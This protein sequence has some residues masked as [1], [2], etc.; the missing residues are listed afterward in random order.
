MPDDRMAGRSPPGFG[1]Q[2]PAALVSAFVSDVADL[3]QKEI[4]LA[5][6][7]IQ[8]NVSRK[9]RGSV[10]LAVAGLVF[11]AAGLTLVAG[12]ALFITTYGFALYEAAFIVAAALVVLGVIVMVVGQAR[13]AGE[14]LPARSM[15]SVRQDI[16]IVRET[17]T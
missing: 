17:A 6:G 7:E 2:N 9:I 5:T 12:V 8:H 1:P 14:V 10:W 3:M 16:R 13:L 4:A 15:E 11:L